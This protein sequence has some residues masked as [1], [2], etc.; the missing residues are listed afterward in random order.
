MGANSTKR[1]SGAILGCL[2]CLHARQC[3]G[4]SWTHG[5]LSSCTRSVQSVHRSVAKSRGACASGSL[6][7][8]CQRGLKFEIR[9]GSF[10]AHV[11]CQN[12]VC[13]PCQATKSSRLTAC[14]CLSM[15]QAALCAM[16]ACMEISRRRRWLCSGSSCIRAQW[17]S[18][19][20][21]HHHAMVADCL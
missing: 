8:V 1:N 12:S 16:H 10:L 14:M 2:S 21:T 20:P 18:L 7:S 5:K 15:K 19:H 4:R 6:D 17:L 9:N 3:Q 13:A 11:W